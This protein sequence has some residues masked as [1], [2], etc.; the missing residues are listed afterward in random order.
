MR[1]AFFIL[2]SLVFSMAAVNPANSTANPPGWGCSQKYCMDPGG[3]C[4]DASCG[5][6]GLPCDN[7][8]TD[9][10]YHLCNGEFWLKKECASSWCWCPK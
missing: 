8:W 5:G 2:G 9:M 6:P 3:F 10:V 4:K 7:C 1:T